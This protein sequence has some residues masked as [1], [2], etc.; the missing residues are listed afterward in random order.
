MA[1]LA[2]QNNENKIFD[3]NDAEFFRKKLKK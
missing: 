3:K 2:N 1:N